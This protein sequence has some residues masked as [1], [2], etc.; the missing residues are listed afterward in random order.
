MRFNQ[1]PERRLQTGCGWRR[2]VERRADSM[3]SARRERLAL[4]FAAALLAFGITSGAKGDSRD[5]SSSARS[6]YVPAGYV[7]VFADEFDGARFDTGK[8]WTRLIYENGAKDFLNDER[9]RYR[10]NGNHI[11]SDGS[12]KL[13]AKKIRDEESYESGV[14]RSKKTL[15]YGYFETRAKLPRG[16]G[17]WPGFWLNSSTSSNGTAVWPPEIDIFEYVLNETEEKPNFMHSDVKVQP[18]PNP[19]QI[20]AY[21]RTNPRY[22]RGP[23]DS[24][25]YYNA[26]FDF[27]DGWHVYGALWDSDD[28][29]TIYIDGVEIQKRRY[30]WVNSAAT[31]GYAHVIL[32]LAIGG[33]WAG[34]FG[35]DE[36]AFPQSV[37]FDYVRVY[38]KAD[39]IMTG[40]DD[41]GQDRCPADRPC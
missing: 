7:S 21:I 17:T 33:H 26:P 3:M 16:K 25:N 40:T 29:V 38:Q 8:W 10:E 27:R 20:G 19:P 2:A 30:L 39:S 15:K 31:P 41:V 34:K 5:A 6:Q 24:L 9:Q 37:E 32:Q 4:A 28:T 22:V 35:V 18:G 36:S 14:A 23:N 12:L 11:V 13:V 1:N